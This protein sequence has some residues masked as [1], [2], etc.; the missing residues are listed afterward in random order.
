VRH[1][2][3]VYAGAFRIAGQ[4]SNEDCTYKMIHGAGV[5]TEDR[6]LRDIVSLLEGAEERGQAG[7]NA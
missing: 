5:R 7:K 2:G 1:S 3:L 6:Q 4:Q